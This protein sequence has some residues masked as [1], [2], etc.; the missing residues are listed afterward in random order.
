MVERA[1]RIAPDFPRRRRFAQLILEPG[2]LLNAE[3][4]SRRPL[5][6][7]IWNAH[8]AELEFGGRSPPIEGASCVERDHRLLG[9][10]SVEGRVINF[11]DPLSVSWV[12]AAEA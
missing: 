3:D 11:P 8:I 2:L 7:R 1:E 4:G 12:V 10:H 5:L 9:K 6:A